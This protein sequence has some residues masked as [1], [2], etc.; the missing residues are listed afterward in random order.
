MTNNHKTVN[1]FITNYAKEVLADQIRQSSGSL[2]QS[3]K[4]AIKHMRGQ[5]VILSHMKYLIAF[6]FLFSEVTAQDLK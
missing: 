6:I 1:L 2:S 3:S 5:W 4:K